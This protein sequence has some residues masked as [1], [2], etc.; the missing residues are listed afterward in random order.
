M[1]VDLVAIHALWDE[2]ADIEAAHVEQA[3]ERLLSGLCRLAGAQNACWIGAV[4]MGDADARDPV[5]GWR[6]R[7]LH[8]LHALPSPMAASVR[9]R[10]RGQQTGNG[11][12]DLS[13]MRNVCFAGEYRAFLLSELV[14][15]EWFEGDYYKTVYR[16]NG[17]ADTIWAGVP[18][19]E[20]AEIYFGVYRYNHA[21][22]FTTA[23]RDTV[24]YVLR[25]L[26]WFHRQQMLG[27]GLGI[28][29]APLT[30]TERLVLS[31][32]L[33]GLREKEVAAD[34]EQSP[35]TTHVHV[36]RIYRKYGVNNR[37]GLMALWLGGEPRT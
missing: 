14:P 37:A 18:I 25:G 24:A 19:N 26:R 33:R 3:R 15:P 8:Y 4:R 28:G 1:N 16:G 11:G 12:T 29:T 13:T 36:T 32:L 27:H 20:D 7:L 30:P 17:I 35:G 34:L 9:A 31:G 6:P 23:E 2:L 5:L 22:A 21:P 10:I